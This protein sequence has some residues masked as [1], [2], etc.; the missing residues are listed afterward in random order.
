MRGGWREWAEELARN[1]EAHNQDSDWQDWLA[2]FSKGLEE[3]RELAG[4]SLAESANLKELHYWPIP[5]QM[6]KSGKL[7]HNNKTFLEY[8]NDW[9]Y[10][11]FSSYAH[12]SLRGLIMRSAGLRPAKDPKAERVRAWR[13][14]KQRSDVLVWALLMSLAATSEIDSACDFGLHIRLRYVW[15]VLSGFFGAAKSLY[16]LRYD[17][18]LRPADA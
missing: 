1:K 10:K 15:G 16:D 17:A 5:G 2:E 4:I 18:I 9:Y 8:L 12:L 14:D 3:T 11:E 7:T 13:V 6:L